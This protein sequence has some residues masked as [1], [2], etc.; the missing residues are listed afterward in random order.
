VPGKGCLSLADCKRV[1]N[2]ELG[3]NRQACEERIASAGAQSCSE[4]DDCASGACREERIGSICVDMVRCGEDGHCG[5][6]SA[7]LFDPSSLDPKAEP[8]SLGACADGRGESLCYA[9]DD[10]VFGRCAGQRCTAGLEGETCTSNGNCASG[11]CRTTGTAMAGVELVGS[12][13]SGERGGGCTDDSDC[14]DDLHCTGTVCFTDGVGE[15]CERDDQCA[16]S[17]CIGSRCRGGEPGSQC[18][19]DGDCVSGVCAGFRCASGLALS[20]CYEA[21]DCASGLSCLRSLCSDGSEHMPC[22]M[23]SDCTPLASVPGICSAGENRASCDADDEC[24]SA[25]CADP[26]GASRGQCTSGATGAHCVAA[27]DCV[28]STCAFNGVCE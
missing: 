10:C 5:A 15:N 14:G 12:C 2:R 13:V 26:P 20:P 3:L 4:D 23:D 24:V 16:S 28:S 11:F 27:D 21:N 25:R 22:A 19:D 7:C 18:E 8:T 6:G 1:C 17:T 9:D